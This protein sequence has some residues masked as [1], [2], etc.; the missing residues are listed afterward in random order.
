[1][2]PS[3]SAVRS[4]L[5]RAAARTVRA[6]CLRQAR[7]QS[8]SSTASGAAKGGSSHVAAGVAGGVAASAVLY[9]AYLMTPS[10]KMSRTINKGAYEASQ[11]YNQAV[12]KLQQSTPEPDEAINYIKEFCYSYVSW[13]PG[14]RQY[15]DAVFRDVETLRQ[16]HRDEVN[17]I[18]NDGYK[19]FQELSKKGLSMETASKAYEVLA[20]LSKKLGSLAGDALTDI[21]D[22]HPQ[23][24]EKFGGSIDQ[25]KQMGEEYGPEA[26][27]QVDETWNQVKEIM[28]GGF[29]AANLDKAR[30]IVQENVEKV[31]KFGDEAWNKGLEQAK[32][33]LDKNPKVREL[34]E[35]NAEALKQGNAKELFEKARS[36]VDSSNLGDFEK[37][38]NSAVDK[39]KSKGSQLAGGS[40]DQYFSMIPSGSEILSK[41]QQLKQVAEE[42]SGEA[43]KLLKETMEEVKKVLEKKYEEAEKIKEQAK[44][45]SK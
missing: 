12:K 41:V 36:A 37:Y 13:V 42:H 26:K 16:N 15:V 32:P 3:T 40:L 7:F 35:N 24:K 31:K 14:G 18:V 30:R 9:G 4:T 45:E 8:T 17:Q 23:V 19:Q 6:P 34:V 11:K 25:L 38:V 21:L 2:M 44:K 1:M 29:T 20:D 43:E 39:A 27:K 33:Y 5:P 28:A 10:G 22:N